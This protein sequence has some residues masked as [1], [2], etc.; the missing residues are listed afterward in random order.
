MGSFESG[1]LKTL[2]LVRL[3]L[4][5]LPEH[6]YIQ[7]DEFFQ[8]TEPL[9][10][11]V[12]GVR[13]YR[14]WEFT[15][16]KPLRSMFFPLAIAGPC[17]K[18]IETL[19]VYS[20]ASPWLTL[21]LPRLIFTLLSFCADAAISLMVKGHP[22]G[23]KTRLAFASSYVA[24][25]YLTHT[26]TNS[27][28][29]ILF[30]VLI[31]L[32]LKG[33]S[34][35]QKQNLFMGII[36]SL[37]FFNRP[38]F[39]CFAFVPTLCKIFSTKNMNKMMRSILSLSFSFM[40]TSLVMIATDS[41]YHN[42]TFR[43]AV[44]SSDFSTL[45]NLDQLV[46]TPFNFL[47]YN[48]KASNLANHGL[49]PWYF[50]AVVSIPSIGLFFG[51]SFYLDIV[52]RI[53]KLRSQSL[54]DTSLKLLIFILA[55][56]VMFSVI[57]HQEPRFLIPCIIPLCLLYGIKLKSKAKLAL[58][59]TSN[60]VLTLFYGFVHQAGVTRALFELKDHLKQDI[61]ARQIVIFSRTYLPPQHL[62]QLDDSAKN[63]AF[64]DLSIYDFPD[65]VFE[66]LLKIDDK[67]R[68]VLYLTLP[69]CFAS[70]VHTLFYNTGF[71]KPT[72]VNRNFPHFTG[73]DL[74]LSLRTFLTTNDIRSAFSLDVWRTEKEQK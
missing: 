21:V 72:L 49:H 67:A 29:T 55:P 14:P 3:V 26:F 25:T 37:G 65:P 39:V 31:C 56:L 12:L 18:L 11:D 58:W 15:A 46:I 61:D 52:K 68:T 17:F 1:F 4:C 24:L 20:E 36:L 30:A 48:T 54:Q 66:K 47:A 5:L 71:S 33:K 19:K 73:E 42:L 50:H 60:L 38:T 63:I 28:E 16:E 69:S 9:G 10:G 7:P 22:T 57:P 32:T 34:T 8:F 74:S 53:F 23:G 45:L 40:A 27:I 64:E 43:S 59:L 35:S 41:M 6:G 51:A 62:L 70:Q 2:F 13:V 44:L